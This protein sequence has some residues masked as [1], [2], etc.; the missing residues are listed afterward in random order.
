MVAGGADGEH[1]VHAGDVA[2]HNDEVIGIG[3]H[4]YIF[5]VRQMDRATCVRGK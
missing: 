4:G 3:R 1:R 5:D 2:V